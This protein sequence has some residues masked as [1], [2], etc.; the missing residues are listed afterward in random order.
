MRSSF[1]SRLKS[2]SSSE[3]SCESGRKNPVQISE[4]FYLWH[5]TY[6]S[7]ERTAYYHF[8][9]FKLL[10]SSYFSCPSFY[11]FCKLQQTC[12]KHSESSNFSPLTHRGHRLSILSNFAILYYDN[13]MVH[14][15]NNE[16]PYVCSECHRRFTQLSALNAHSLTH[17][18]TGRKSGRSKPSLA[19]PECNL[20]FRSEGVF[21]VHMQS[22]HAR[23]STCIGQPLAS[24]LWVIYIL[25]LYSCNL[26][27]GCKKY[28]LNQ[29]INS[30]FH[31]QSITDRQKILSIVA[32]L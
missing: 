1:Q 26:C 14:F 18:Q 29:I 20:V 17:S 10:L 27:I 2:E 25:K 31:F 11:N 8:L 24:L 32:N 28:I 5:R 6:C 16:K 15:Q 21:K 9:A 7:I 22:E 12:L 13:N 23:Y 19:C 4:Y 30:Y 3:N